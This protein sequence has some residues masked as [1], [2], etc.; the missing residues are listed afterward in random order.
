MIA[1]MSH[2][3][4]KIMYQGEEDALFYNKHIIP[5]HYSPLKLAAFYFN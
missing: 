5:L 4:S 2:N 3:R 1:W